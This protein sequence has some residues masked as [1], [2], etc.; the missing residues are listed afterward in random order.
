MALSFRCLSIDEMEDVARVHG[1]A[2]G[3]TDADRDYFRGPVFEACQVWGAFEDHRLLGFVAFREGWIDH[4]CVEPSGQ[5]RG[6]GSG[7][8]ALAQDGQSAVKVRASPAN[9]AARRFCEKHGFEP[10][11][12]EGGLVTYVRGEPD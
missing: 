2:G 10:G 12:D 11:S 7:L 4:L 1:A 5:R 9:E 6:V 8:L 3:R